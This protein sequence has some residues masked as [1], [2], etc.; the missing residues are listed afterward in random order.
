MRKLFIK[1]GVASKVRVI[2]LSIA[3]AFLNS[4]AFGTTPARASDPIQI[5]WASADITPTAPTLLRG[6]FYARFSEGVHDSLY[7]TALAITSADKPVA[8]RVV[9][10]SCDMVTVPD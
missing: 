10:V 7:V 4:I 9:M 8:T 5:G 6:Q 2:F 1:K 3:F